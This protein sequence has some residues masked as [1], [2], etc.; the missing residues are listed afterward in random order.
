VGAIVTVMMA[1]RAL[2]ASSSAIMHECNSGD[3]TGDRTSV[4]G[5]M[6]AIFT[7]P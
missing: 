4:V 2:G 5:Y 6:S 7:T 3:I 1:A